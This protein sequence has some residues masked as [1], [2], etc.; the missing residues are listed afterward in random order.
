MKI[1]VGIIDRTIRILV[2]IAVLSLL[3]IVDGPNRWFGLLGLV[4]IIIGVT[5]R[6]PLFMLLGISSCPAEQHPST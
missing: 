2:G 6:C 1:N 4:P 5:R 3:F